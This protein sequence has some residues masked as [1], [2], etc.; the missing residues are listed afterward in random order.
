MEER[1]EMGKNPALNIKMKIAVVGDVGVDYYKNL[2]LVKPGG[3]AFNFAYG[4]I[5]S[6]QKS[7]SLVSAI[8]ND[9][10]SKELLVLIKKLKIK[11]DH[12]QKLVGNTPKQDIILLN[13]ERKFIGYDP[14]ILKKW[15][16]KDEDLKFLKRQNAIF[17]PL[18]DGM[19]NIFGKPDIMLKW[20]QNRGLEHI[21]VGAS[22][23]LDLND[24]NQFQEHNLGTETSLITGAI[25]IN[26]VHELLK[27]RKE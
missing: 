3:I 24:R 7:V 2:D 14:G 26:Y 20:D 5:S 16:L 27:M 22:G 23:G 15:K 10:Y 6:G 18:S 13:G 1:V 19:E 9:R 4:L 11:I 21:A 17:V 25:A 12:M 8:G